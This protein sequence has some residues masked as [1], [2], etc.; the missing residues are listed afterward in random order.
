[1][2]RARRCQQQRVLLCH[3]FTK[4]RRSSV[5][6]SEEVTYQQRRPVHSTADVKKPANHRSRPHCHTHPSPHTPQAHGNGTTVLFQVGAY[7]HE[8]ENLLSEVP[9][10]VAS[11]TGPCRKV[12]QALKFIVKILFNK[13][14]RQLFDVFPSLRTLHPT[15]EMRSKPSLSFMSCAC[16]HLYLSVTSHQKR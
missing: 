1:M 15:Q 10:R 2:C 13:P 16:H 14:P 6:N 4:R 9:L 3:R 5:S 7:G 11:T 8:S 12:V